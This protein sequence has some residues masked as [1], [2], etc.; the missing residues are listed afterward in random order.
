MSEQYEFARGFPTA[1]TLRQV[2]DEVDL[3]RAVQCYRMFYPSVSGLAI[4]RGNRA[5]GLVD[6][7]VFGTLQTQP[8]HVGLTLNSDTLCGHAAQPEAGPS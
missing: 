8:K 1:E 5:L 7:E 4:F 6:N 3:N 2:Y